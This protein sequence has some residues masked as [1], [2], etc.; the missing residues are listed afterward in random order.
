[1]GKLTNVIAY[2][3]L[4]G[5]Q[6][7]TVAIRR[8]WLGDCWVRR[9][10]CSGEWEY[11]GANVTDIQ[12]ALLGEVYTHAKAA[13]DLRER[14]I[15]WQKAHA[16]EADAPGYVYPDWVVSGLSQ[17]DHEQGLANGVLEELT[18]EGE[19][20]LE[21]VCEDERKLAARIEAFNRAQD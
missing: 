3:S 10:T 12:R 9:D 5:E 15:S 17:L 11:R 18:R 6:G 14:L 13:C 16:A 1:M 7:A 8:G 2:N 21:M 20:L 19:G 4:Q